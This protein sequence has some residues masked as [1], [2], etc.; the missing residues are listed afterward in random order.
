MVVATAY[1]LNKH[2][3]VDAKE[4]HLPYIMGLVNSKQKSLLCIFPETTKRT[5]EII[6]KL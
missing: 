3:E 4:E 2:N 5:T 1:H 6:Q